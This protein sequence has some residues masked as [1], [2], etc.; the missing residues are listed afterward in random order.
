MSGAFNPFLKWSVHPSWLPVDAVQPGVHAHGRGQEIALHAEELSLRDE[1]EGGRW[2]LA[3][4]PRSRELFASRGVIFIW[5]APS[6][7]PSV[8]TH[9][10]GF[11]SRSSV[12]P[13]R[14]SFAQHAQQEPL[15]RQGDAVG[16]HR[17]LSPRHAGG[18]RASA[19]CGLHR[20]FSPASGLLGCPGHDDILHRARMA[21]DCRFGVGL[22]ARRRGRPLSM[23]R[24][25]W[26]RLGAMNAVPWNGRRWAWIRSR[27]A[28]GS[29]SR[30]KPG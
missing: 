27:G 2:D 15:D 6:G 14:L 8:V 13:L 3:P 28:G 16:R 30:R 7:R 17:P 18:Q 5:V 21:L 29:G 10:R 11:G 9:A 26:G 12:A 23:A 25:A 24:I 4:V 22:G 20:C 19:G 1:T